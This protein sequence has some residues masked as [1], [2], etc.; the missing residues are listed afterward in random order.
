MKKGFEQGKSGD[1]KNS[2]ETVTI[3]QVANN[4]GLCYDGN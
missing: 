3:G 2:L 1:Q 4:E